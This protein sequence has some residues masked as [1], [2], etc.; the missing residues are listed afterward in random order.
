M[1]FRHLI[2]YCT[3]CDSDTT[4]NDPPSAYVSHSTLTLSRDVYHPFF[5]ND[6]FA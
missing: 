3:L 5:L 6:F 1:H 2:I 4:S